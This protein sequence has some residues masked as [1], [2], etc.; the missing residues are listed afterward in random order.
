[1]ICF[2]RGKPDQFG[3]GKTK[4]SNWLIEL[5]IWENMTIVGIVTTRQ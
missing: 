3:D 2:Y 5:R 4:M 1:V